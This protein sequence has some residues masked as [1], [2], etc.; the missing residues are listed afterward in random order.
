MPDISD[1]LAQQAEQLGV[2]IFPAPLQAG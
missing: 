1:W 2:D